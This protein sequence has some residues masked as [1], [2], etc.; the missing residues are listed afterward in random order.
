MLVRWLTIIASPSGFCVSAQN[1]GLEGVCF[2]RDLQ[3]LILKAVNSRQLTVES[4][5]GDGTG[6]EDCVGMTGWRSIFTNHA[7]TFCWRSQYVYYEDNAKHYPLYLRD[8]CATS[9]GPH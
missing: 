1:K 7:S 3:V 6:A 5:R 9:G 2:D 4:R 8:H